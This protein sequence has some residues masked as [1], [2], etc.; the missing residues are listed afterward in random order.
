MV[1]V[2][3]NQPDLL[4]ACVSLMDRCTATQEHVQV[5]EGH[6]RIETRIVQTYTPVTGWLPDGWSEVRQIVRVSR[7][8]ERKESSGIWKTSH[9]TACWIS[10]IALSAAI[11]Q[12]GIRGHWCVVNQNHHVRDVTL[13]EVLPRSSK[14]CHPGSLAV[15]LPELHALMRRCQ[16]GRR[17]VSKCTQLRRSR[18]HGEKDL[19]ALTYGL[20]SVDNQRSQM[21]AAASATNDENRSESFS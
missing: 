20:G 19:T 10:T 2:K 14:A 21:N 16:Y 6:G 7:A 11:C 5:D 12:A 18:C 4:A 1:Q 3:G 15:C 17:R 13:R 9:E 8:V